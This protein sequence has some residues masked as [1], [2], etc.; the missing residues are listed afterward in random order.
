VL[1]RVGVLG[2]GQ[3][4]QAVHGEARAVGGREHRATLVRKPE[5]QML[6]GVE[7]ARAITTGVERGDV[8]VRGVTAV[9]G[10]QPRPDPLRGARA[11]RLRPQVERG[12]RP[13]QRL[14]A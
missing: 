6:E 7:L 11:E 14:G 10:G 12:R 1:R 3:F 4:A 2:V 8:L 5:Q 13:E 9:V